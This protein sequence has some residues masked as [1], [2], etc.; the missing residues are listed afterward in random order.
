M[1]GKLDFSEKIKKLT[2]SQLIIPVIAL[3]ILVVFNLIRDP[4][5]FLIGI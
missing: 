2:S 4:S 5:F 3:L 1:K